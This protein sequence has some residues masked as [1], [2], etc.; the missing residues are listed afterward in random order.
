MFIHLPQTLVNRHSHD[1]VPTLATNQHR[2]TTPYD[3]HATLTHLVNGKPDPQLPHGLSLFTPISENRECSAAAIPDMFCSCFAENVVTDY[4]PFYMSGIIGQIVNKINSLTDSVREMCAKYEYESIARVY[5]RENARK[6]SEYSLGNTTYHIVQMFMNP[7][8]AL[9][10]TV[11][12]GVNGTAANMTIVGEISRINRYGNQSHCI[13]DKILKN[14]CFF[15]WITSANCREPCV[16]RDYGYGSTVCVCN[17]KHCDDLEPIEKTAA[18]VVTVYETS[19]SG[20]RFDKTVLN[21]GSNRGRKATKS[22]TI[23]IDKSKG[24][25]QRILGF[26]GAFTDS[27]GL[28]IK[29]LPETLQNRIIGDYFADTGVE[30]TLGRIPIGGSDFST[31][32]YSYDDNSTDDFQFK[33]WALADEDFKYKIPLLKKAQEVSKHGIKYMA[34]PWS[35][36]AWMKTN[37]KL[38]NGGFLVGEPGGKYHKA[39]AQYLIKFLDAYKANGVSLWGLTIDNEPISGFMPTYAWNSLGF[40]PETQRDFLKLDLGPALQAAGY[41]PNTTRVMICDD[42]RAFIDSWANTIYADRE[43]SKY[44]AGLAF[45][46]Y[47]NTDANIDKLDIAHLADP[48]KFLINTE[49]CEEWKDQPKH[50]Q[51]GNWATFERYANDIIIDLNH[52]TSGW[53]DWNLA[54]DETGGPNWAKNMVD[55]PV[56][57]NATARE[58][59]KQPI[60]YAMGHFSKFLP[61]GAQRVY[62]STDKSVV[63]LQTTTFI[64]PDGGTAVLA[65]NMG[66]EPID[67]TIND[68]RLKR[69]VSHILAARSMQT[70][71]YY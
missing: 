6:D 37:H 29:S 24:L 39:Y 4:R 65:L 8:K 2:L 54:L 15:T 56:I 13:N 3:I 67:I 40:T 33:R 53:V 31:R 48:D 62:Q 26:G 47:T 63:G 10:E 61:P 55:A 22:Q 35:P 66:D 49:A 36:P 20:H 1:W 17:E 60:F 70:Y 12:K 44:V 18:G 38:N 32:A 28:N 68:K 59:Y 64:R 41:G 45:H 11:I 19:K 14:Y 34:S 16:H 30:Y 58:Y 51:L 9:F 52:W 46:W 25:Y 43:A 5:Q 23:T 71:L 27:A 57:V 42:Q 50:V 69:N 7:G 21:V